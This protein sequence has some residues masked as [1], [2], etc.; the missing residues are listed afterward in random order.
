MCSFRCRGVNAPDR[1][2]ATIPRCLIEYIEVDHMFGKH[3]VWIFCLACPIAEAHFD[4]VCYFS[5]DTD[6][7]ICFYVSSTRNPAPGMFAWKIPLSYLE[8]QM[9]D[10]LVSQITTVSYL[11]SH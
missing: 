10:R 1:L 7:R 5:P 3:Y 4:Y 6:L 2:L 11:S 9:E 8:V